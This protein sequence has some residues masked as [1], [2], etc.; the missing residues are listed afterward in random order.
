MDFFPRRAINVKF[1]RVNKPGLTLEK[2]WGPLYVLLL[3]ELQSSQMAIHLW[4][5]QR[6][7]DFSGTC[8]WLD[9]VISS[10]N[11]L[12]KT[13]LKSMHHPHPISSAATIYPGNHAL[14]GKVYKHLLHL[15]PNLVSTWA[16][17]PPPIDIHLKPFMPFHDTENKIRAPHQATGTAGS[18]Q[19]HGLCSLTSPIMCSLMSFSLG[20][21]PQAAASPRH[22]FCLCFSLYHPLSHPV[23]HSFI[24]FQVCKLPLHFVCL[25]PVPSLSPPFQIKSWTSQVVLVIKNP[26]ANAGHI[27]DTGSIPGLG[28]SPGGGQGNPLQYSSLENSMDREAWRATIHSVTNSQ[29]QLKWLS[30][31][32]SIYAPSLSPPLEW[33]SPEGRDKDVPCFIYS[34][35][36][37]PCVYWLLKRYLLNERRNKRNNLSSFLSFTLNLSLC[38]SIAP[39]RWNPGD[40]LH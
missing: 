3:T 7:L 29:I 12:S 11:F 24:T 13:C 40:N 28:R 9:S 22:A 37:M 31:H 34:F 4:N 5:K 23:F 6:A 39:L 25:A 1:Q 32:V 35:L 19:T 14:Q 17:S 8:S 36:N 27:R 26:A 33:K 18:S 38:C 20:D 16:V 15:P 30:T 21:F 2:F 10:V